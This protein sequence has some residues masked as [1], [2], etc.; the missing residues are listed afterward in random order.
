MYWGRQAY[1]IRL[2]DFDGRRR[3][4]AVLPVV[5]ELVRALLDLLQ[6]LV[7]LLALVRRRLSV[8]VLPAHRIA[9]QPR[10]LCF[11]GEVLLGDL[12]VVAV[13]DLGGHA[14]HAED[15]NVQALPPAN[16]ILDM[17]EVLLVDLVHVHRETCP[18]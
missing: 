9:R 8:R 1:R 16:C 4:D 11:L 10:A 2:R 12:L 13:E 15:L 18:C 14:L 3:Q 17:C 5:S 7:D 6:R